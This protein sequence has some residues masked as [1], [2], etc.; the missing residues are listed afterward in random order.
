MNLA[1]SLGGETERLAGHDLSGRNPRLRPAREHHADRGRTLARRHVASAR[2]PFA[3]GCNAAPRRTHRRPRRDRRRQERSASPVEPP[4]LAA[5]RLRTGGLPIG[6]A[7]AV[8][9][10]AGAVGLGEL[11]T[12]WISL[13]NVSM[14]FLTAV[15]VC[16]AWFGVR[17]AIAAAILSFFAYD[18]FFIPPLY[19]FTIAEPQEFFALSIFLIVAFWLAGSRAARAIRS[20]SRARALARRDR[21]SNFRESFRARSRSAT[22]SKPRPSMPTKRS[23]PGGSSCC[24]PRRPN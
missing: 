7:A 12:L 16:A 3:I 15:L 22:Y 24:C 5:L 20:G 17:A 9:S 8:L 11:L 13:P 10:V 14:I 18:F 23:A 2:R 1:R 19:E 6:F 21:C 4:W